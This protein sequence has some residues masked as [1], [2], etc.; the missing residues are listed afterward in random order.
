M[1]QRPWNSAFIKMSANLGTLININVYF[2]GSRCFIINLT[3]ILI[4]IFKSAILKVSTCI[5]KSVLGSHRIKK[6]HLSCRSRHYTY[7]VCS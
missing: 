1:V 5:I 2:A 6:E 4:L 7:I 3:N